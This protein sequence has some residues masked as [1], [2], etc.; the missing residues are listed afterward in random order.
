M[1]YISKKHESD[2]ERFKADAKEVLDYAYAMLVEKNR[3]YR[4]S[5]LNP[6]KIFSQATPEERILD[7]LDDKVSRLAQGNSDD[8][9]DVVD[10]MIGYLVMLKIARKRGKNG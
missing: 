8:D 2:H 7:R 1:R 3:H 5:I 4:D 9:E 10:D 6:V